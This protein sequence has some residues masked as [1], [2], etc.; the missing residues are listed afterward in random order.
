MNGNKINN[1]ESDESPWITAAYA[2]VGLYL[3]VQM[4]YLIST[5]LQPKSVY[6]GS[7]QDPWFGHREWNTFR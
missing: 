5:L 2:L 3:A 1:Y 4:A 6:D 7:Q